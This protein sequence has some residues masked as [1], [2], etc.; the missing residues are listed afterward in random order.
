[1]TFQGS[2][3]VAGILCTEFITELIVTVTHVVVTF[4][5][6][7]WLWLHPIFSAEKRQKSPG[8]KRC[9]V[10]LG[11][12]F[13]FVEKRQLVLL[14]TPK[15]SNSSG[16]STEIPAQKEPWEVSGLTSCSRRRLS[17]DWVTPGFVLRAGQSCPCAS[18]L[19]GFFPTWE[20]TL[21]KEEMKVWRPGENQGKARCQPLHSEIP[22]LSGS[23]SWSPVSKAEIIMIIFIIVIPN[24]SQD[25]PP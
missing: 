3:W 17:S 10:L 16:I 7:L 14:N 24:N 2:W 6:N 9:L 8:N 21:E 15:G 13:L 25:A 1:M 12:V 23:H 4:S 20:K 18:R 19:P 11:G 5:P 22:N